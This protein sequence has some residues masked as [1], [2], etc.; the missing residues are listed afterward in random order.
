MHTCIH[1]SYTYVAADCIQ[2]HT[3]AP[4][5]VES[6]GPYKNFR[7]VLRKLGG[8]L[9][10]HFPEISAEICLPWSESSSCFRGNKRRM[11]LFGLWEAPWAWPLVL[12]RVRD[13]G[14][15]WASLGSVS[16]GMPGLCVRLAHA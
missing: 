10:F 8:L 3:Y 2:V 15:S 1:V 12:E 9:H 5:R 16:E 6:F 4:S 11:D 7:K 14:P 13:E